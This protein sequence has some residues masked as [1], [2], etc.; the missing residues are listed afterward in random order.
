M[1]EPLLSSRK[2]AKKWMKFCKH[3]REAVIDEQ[4]AVPDYEKL[5]KEAQKTLTTVE[6][7]LPFER[8]VQRIIADEAR[9]KQEL[10]TY[11]N[12]VCPRMAF[13]REGIKE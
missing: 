2:D 13:H 6:T 5:I 8:S 7:F 4:K 12:S 3:L 1:G 11:F 9:H 10:L